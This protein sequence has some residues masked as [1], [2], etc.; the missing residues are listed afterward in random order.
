LRRRFG[1]DDLVEDLAE[2]IDWLCLERP[3]VVGLSFGGVI[4]LEYAGLHPSRVEALAVQGVG[5]RLDKGLVQRVASAVLADYPLP[6]DSAFVNQFFNLLYGCRPEPGPLFDFVTQ[7]SWQT[8]QSVMAHRFRLAEQYDLEGRLERIQAPA[9]VLHGQRDTLV[10]A[11][12]LKSLITE[13]PNARLTQ[14]PGC[15]HLAFVTHPQRVAHEL[16]QFLAEVE[17]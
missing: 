5:V 16:S 15:G 1:L 2:F 7:Q 13:I 11:A 14:L 4:A 8:D 17:D 6:S 10:S 9:L 12:S 3:T